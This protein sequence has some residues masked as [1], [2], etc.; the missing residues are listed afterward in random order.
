MP[1]AGL[2]RMREFPAL[3]SGFALSLRAA[4]SGRG[5]WRSLLACRRVAAPAVSAISAATTRAAGAVQRG[6]T[7]ALQRPL[8]GASVLG[9]GWPCPAYCSGTA[10][11][12]QNGG[13]GWLGVKPCGSAPRL[14]I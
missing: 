1:L 2:V 8:S 14:V 7:A 6:R 12:P 10:S 9:S 11:L 5:V 13:E 4:G 3:S